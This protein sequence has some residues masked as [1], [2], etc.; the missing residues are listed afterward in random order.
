MGTDFVLN[1]GCSLVDEYREEHGSDD[2]ASKDAE[3]AA[4]LS[5]NAKIAKKKTDEVF[6]QF[7]KRQ[8]EE[9]MLEPKPTTSSSISPEAESREDQEDEG[10][11]E[12]GDEDGEDEDGDDNENEDAEADE[13]ARLKNLLDDGDEEDN[14]DGG[15][16]LISWAKQL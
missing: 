1:F 13:A 8:E 14:E 2:P 12:G 16:Q 5:E 7:V 6:Q 15:E 3:L 9:Q 11:E 10:D 4:K